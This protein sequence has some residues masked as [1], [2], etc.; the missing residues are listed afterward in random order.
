MWAQLKKIQRERILLRFR[1]HNRDTLAK[2]VTA[3]VQNF[4]RNIRKYS[5]LSSVLKEIKSF[6]KCLMLNGIKGV[7]TSER[8]PIQLGTQVVESN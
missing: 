4:W 3:L 7:V 6:S 2:I 5:W 1:D 8:D